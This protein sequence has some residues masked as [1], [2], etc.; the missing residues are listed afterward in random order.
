MDGF[1]EII[2]GRE[3]RRRRSVEGRLRMVAE[4]H[5]PGVRDE[6]RGTEPRIEAAKVRLRDVLTRA[7]R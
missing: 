4:T 3:R 5:E 1:V 2:T 7:G 6:D